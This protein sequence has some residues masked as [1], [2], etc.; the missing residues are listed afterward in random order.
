VPDF[1]LQPRDNEGPT[2]NEP[3][4]AQAF[5]LVLALYERGLFSW[6]E[7]AMALHNAIHAAQESGD[8]DLGDT[9]YVHWLEALEGLVKEKGMAN[10]TELSVRKA[11]WHAA[12]M[13]T[14][15]GLP[16]Q[17]SDGNHDS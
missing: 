4:E 13:H 5:G 7:W 3:W 6:E 10:V 12:Y 1:Y 9:Y 14:P 16:V 2:F 15:H 11:Q 8:M 17:L